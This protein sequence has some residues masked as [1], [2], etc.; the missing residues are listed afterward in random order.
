MII[1]PEAPMEGLKRK[2]RN[3]WG[4]KEEAVKVEMLESLDS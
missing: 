3:D 4:R 1:P 2:E